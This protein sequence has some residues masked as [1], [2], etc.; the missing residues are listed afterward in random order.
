LFFVSQFLN[1]G[2]GSYWLQGEN[3][4]TK[5]KKIQSD[6]ILVYRHVFFCDVV[7][8]HWVIGIRRFGK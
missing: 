2:C 1:H 3:F 8:R 6:Q 4:P 7:P 5:E